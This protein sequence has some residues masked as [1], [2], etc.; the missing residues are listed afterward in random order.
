M[1]VVRVFRLRFDPKEPTPGVSL[2]AAGRKLGNTMKWNKLLV[3]ALLLVSSQAFPFAKY[4]GDFLSTGIGARA[5]GMGGAFVS[6]ADDASA[7]YWNPAGMIF[8]QSREMVFMHSERFGDLVNYDA[9]G[10][11]QQLGSDN[12][13]RSAFGF[14]FLRTGVDDIP[15]TRQNAVTGRPEVERYVSD[16]EWGFLLSYGR[17]W[18]SRLAVGGSA[19]VLR[20]SVGDDSA[21]GIGFDV[22]GLLRPWRSLSIGWNAQDV[23][24]TFLAWKKET[25]TILPTLKLGASYPFRVPSIGGRLTLAADLDARFEGRKYATTYWLGESSADLR[26][27]VEYWYADRLALRIGQERSQENNLTAGAGFRIPFGKNSL[28][29]DYAF[30]THSDLDD[31][32]RVSGSFVF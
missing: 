25:E 8:V 11:V 17:L 5:L 1:F 18:T 15:Y 26:L 6:V 32:H 9:G 31:T 13:S 20:K 30:L 2:E 21:L 16:S 12:A 23:T 10:F 19:K 14:S 28:A 24:T 29:L 27:G 22:G 3:P 7:G 4:G